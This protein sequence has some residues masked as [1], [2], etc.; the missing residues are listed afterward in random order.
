MA[1]G[2]DGAVRGDD[3]VAIAHA[4]GVGGQGGVLAREPGAGALVEEHEVA[5]A[6]GVDLPAVV[7][8]RLQHLGPDA[9]L[10]H[11]GAGVAGNELHGHLLL[12]AHCCGVSGSAREP[13]LPR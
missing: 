8:Q 12:R 3:R 7:E 1:D 9:A 10:L 5:A 6:A 4:L 11:A 13:A 2:D